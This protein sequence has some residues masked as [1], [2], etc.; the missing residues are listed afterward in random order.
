MFKMYN[1]TEAVASLNAEHIH[2]L[3]VA[4]IL[5][6]DQDSPSK[7]GLQRMLTKTRVKP[8]AQY[9]LRNGNRQHITPLV[10]WCRIEERDIPMFQ[11][12]FDKRD[13]AGIE[14]LFGDH[15]MTILDGQHRQA[16]LMMAYKEAGGKFNPP[17][18]LQLFFN[19][20]YDQAA[21]I[22]LDI[23]DN[24][25]NV[26][27][28]TRETIRFRIT[29]R[30]EV[31]HD[32]WARG[33]AVHLDENP[34]S[35]WYQEF[36]LVGKGTNGRGEKKKSYQHAFLTMAAV[37]RGIKTLV[38]QNT[39]ARYLKAAGH[40]PSKI[41]PHYW[42]CIRNIVGDD[43]WNYYPVKDKKTGQV[44]YS[45]TNLR[46]LVGFGALCYLGAKIIDDAVRDAHKYDLDILV[47]IRKALEPLKDVDWRYSK[48]NVWMRNVNSGWAGA[49]HLYHNL[50]DY[51]MH[52]IHPGDEQKAA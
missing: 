45:K 50:K 25:K 28:A 44:T 51:V 21:Q 31:D 34:G 12:L 17:I 40:D 52:G 2:N 18:P 35:A 15:A 19:L 9:F 29:K 30:N 6:K 39:T 8:I 10:V 13:F 41:V 26:A 33:M 38:P 3:S 22:F 27:G 43:A 47:A 36:D 7:H 46:N 48:D 11:D 42:G 24:G 14:A 20:S 4:S 37:P 32:Q 1:N 5:D 16:G 23:N 49:G